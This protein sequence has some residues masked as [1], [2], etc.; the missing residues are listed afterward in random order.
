[1][2]FGGL[3]GDLLHDSVTVGGLLLA[4]AR[5]MC[6]DAG[7]RKKLV[8]FRSHSRIPIYRIPD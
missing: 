4:R 3:P 7:E 5:R 2:I 1:M 8:G 6:S